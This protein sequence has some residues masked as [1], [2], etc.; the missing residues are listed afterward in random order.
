MQEEP[1]AYIPAVEF[2][3]S[4]LLLSVKAVAKE[5]GEYDEGV[6]QKHWSS[7]R[8]RKLLTKMP[9][10]KRT[11]SGCSLYTV[12]ISLL[13]S[14]YKWYYGGF[15]G[16]KKEGYLKKKIHHKQKSSPSLRMVD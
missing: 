16:L 7:H 4:Q 1:K 9:I 6:F 2:K 10:F 3:A 5:R 14:L 15:G 12:L 8:I 11:K 13:R